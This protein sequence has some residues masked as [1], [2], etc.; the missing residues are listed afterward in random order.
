MR[1]KWRPVVGGIQH[2]IRHGNA[3]CTIDFVTERN[4][5]DGMIVVSHCTNSDRDIGG[6]TEA[7][8]ASCHQV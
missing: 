2:K 4:N 5:V 8:E 1:S 3:Y 7:V 6:V